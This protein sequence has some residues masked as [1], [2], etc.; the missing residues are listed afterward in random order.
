M[1]RDMGKGAS[2]RFLPARGARSVV[3]C[4]E[5]PAWDLSFAALFATRN[6]ARTFAQA[7]LMLLLSGIKVS[8]DSLRPALWLSFSA[9]LLGAARAVCD[10]GSTGPA[11]AVFPPIFTFFGYPQA[12]RVFPRFHAPFPIPLF[13][14]SPFSSSLARTSRVRV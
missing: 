13:T 12:R 8:I 5:Q 3:A 10:L 11:S 1:A 6:T 4:A 9:I 14:W 2:L 7:C